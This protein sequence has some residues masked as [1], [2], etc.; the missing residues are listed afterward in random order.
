MLT[1]TQA[2]KLMTDC[3]AGSPSRQTSRYP[4]G[5]E[6]HVL[7]GGKNSHSRKT[8]PSA[9]GIDKHSY[10]RTKSDR[11]IKNAG[12]DRPYIP[13]PE[14]YAP[15]SSM[16][17][18]TP[19]LWDFSSHH[20]RGSKERGFPRLLRLRIQAVDAWLEREI[21]RRFRGSCSVGR[22]RRRDFSAYCMVELELGR[23]FFGFSDK[24]DLEY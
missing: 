3:S 17:F 24:C 20:R 14:Y 13:S 8:A 11:Q 15:C 2:I 7:S 6:S 21:N 23:S 12:P 5:E 16:P 1:N 22:L 10:S 9:P 18:R 19:P 4:G